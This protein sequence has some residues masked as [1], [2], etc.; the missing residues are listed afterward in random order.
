MKRR[1]RDDEEP[2]VGSIDK[3][4]L[5]KIGEQLQRVPKDILFQIAAAMP[6]E[7]VIA[8]CQVDVP[9]LVNCPLVFSN[10]Q[11]VVVLF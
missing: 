10:T 2:N 1:D 8:L 9:R 6:Y 11:L 7:S 4:T 5:R 3:E